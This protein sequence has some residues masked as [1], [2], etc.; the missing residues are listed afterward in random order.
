MKKILSFLMVLV[1]ICSSMLMLVACGGNGNGN[2]GGVSAEDITLG[3]VAEKPENYSEFSNEYITF[4]Y[5]SSWYFDDGMYGCSV[6]DVTTGTGINARIPNH[7][8][9]ES[10]DSFIEDLRNEQKETA[11]SPDATVS[12][13]V[14]IKEN[15][16]TFDL[17]LNGQVATELIILSVDDDGKVVY[18]FEI[19][20]SDRTDMQQLTTIINS[21][22][23][24]N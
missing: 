5:P 24:A 2:G 22:Q 19:G 15:V 6:V 7:L 3:S 9:S 18:Y 14:M 16:Y 13:A 8:S 23:F 11:P 1:L 20:Y 4:Y 10:A 21:I 12:E 17:S